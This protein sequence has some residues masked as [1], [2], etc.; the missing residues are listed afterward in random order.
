MFPAPLP[1]GRGH[2]SHTV[3]RDVRRGNALYYSPVR[4]RWSPS[5]PFVSCRRS[6]RRLS[7]EYTSY[8]PRHTSSGGSLARFASGDE[9]MEDASLTR[10][11]SIS[12]SERRS[13]DAIER[14]ITEKNERG[15]RPACTAGATTTALVR[16]TLQI[17]HH[18]NSGSLNSCASPSA[19]RAA[20]PYPARHR[21]QSAARP[22]V[23]SGRASWSQKAPEPRLRRPGRARRPA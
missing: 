13:S 5:V 15:S 9:S 17:C 22:P 6:L 8:S 21:R 20:S 10:F 1:D 7:S 4:Q 12:A 14:T 2:I 16:R 18:V 19:P 3:V 23:D 11:A